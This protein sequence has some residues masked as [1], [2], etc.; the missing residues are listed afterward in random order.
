MTTIL[1]IRH[2][3]TDT[4][5]KKLTGWTKGVHLND[6]GQQQAE[7]LAKRL[8]QAPIKAIY[9]SPLERTLETARPLARSKE[10]QIVSRPGLGEI[11][12]G[13]W[14]GKSIKQLG[15]NKLWP[16]IQYSPSLARFPG[17]ESFTETQA[18]LVAE[19]ETLRIRHPKDLIACFS[20][21]DSIKLIVAH[22][23]GLPLDMFQRLAVSPASIS[24]LQIHSQRAVL[25]RL[26][27][28]GPVESE[29]TTTGSK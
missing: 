20:H 1:L 23:L 27:D 12:Y 29:P 17:G 2:A 15:R 26:N 18:R 3:A 8:E 28:T 24:A 11:R 5:G 25:L 7:A 21:A 4:A 6:K 14:T 10:L 13:Q 16:V 9:S 19:V 22:Y